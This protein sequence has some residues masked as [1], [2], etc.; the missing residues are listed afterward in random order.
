MQLDRTLV[1]PVDDPALAHSLFSHAVQE[2][3]ILLLVVLGTD[4]MAEEAVRYADRR[5]RVVV[6]GRERKVAWVRD[7]DAL[8]DAFEDLSPG[9][10]DLDKEDLSGVLAF[11]LSLDDAVMD[12]IRYDEKLDF[13]RVE[14]AFLFA[15]E[16]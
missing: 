7:P 16:A 12:V 13:V 5:A 4:P 15:G 10:V 1:L 2:E 6:Q 8:M 11:A 14:R 9:R 3:D